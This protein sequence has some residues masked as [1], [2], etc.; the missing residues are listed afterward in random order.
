[1]PRIHTPLEDDE[2]AKFVQW[3]ELKK[4]RFTAIPNSTYTKSWKQKAKNKRVGLR[5]GF[6]DMIVIVNNRLVAIE[7]KR[8]YPPGKISDEQREWIDALNKCGIKAMVCFGGDEAIK[9]IES[10]E[11]QTYERS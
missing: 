1:M 9:F 3:L 10:V 11:K 7:L 4:Y 2:Q 8:I 5:A 6:P